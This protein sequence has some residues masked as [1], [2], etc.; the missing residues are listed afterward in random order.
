ML[1]E[2]ETPFPDPK[3]MQVNLL[4]FM[5]KYGAAHFMEELWKLLLSA[6]ETVGGVP[7]EVSF[8]FDAALSRI[9]RDPILKMLNSAA[10]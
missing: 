1:E 5:D 7:A 4:G 6:Q 2:T 3:K 8:P 9:T 10:S